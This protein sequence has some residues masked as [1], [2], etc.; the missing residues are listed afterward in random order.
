MNESTYFSGFGC[1][2]STDTKESR[3]G[4]IRIH[5]YLF[6]YTELYL[7]SWDDT[8]RITSYKVYEECKV[9]LRRAIL[10]L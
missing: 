2:F 1:K 9:L 8:C 5:E 7:N 3:V 4:K 10:T 6:I